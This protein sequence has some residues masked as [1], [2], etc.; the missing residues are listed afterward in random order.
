MKIRSLV[1]SCLSLISVAAISTSYAADR[2]GAASF[3]VG[4]GSL[5]FASSRD[6]DNTGVPFFGLGYDFTDHWGIEGILGFFNT[7]S[8][9]P[10]DN[11]KQV[12]GTMFLVDGLYHFT[13]YNIVEPYVMLG[14]GILGMNPNGTDA[15]N[16][17]NINAGLGAKV[18]FD[19]SIAF[20][21]EARDLY[22]TVGPKNDYMFDAGV[23]FL[24]DIC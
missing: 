12:N 11:G 8:N 18:F 3:T 21:F 15:N 14:V 19:K 16:E 1:L 13:P 9:N 7:D 23:T 17:G 24:L 2:A 10:E 20:R 4:A 22:T 6:I 5:H